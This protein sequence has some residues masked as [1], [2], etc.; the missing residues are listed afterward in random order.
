MKNKLAIV[1][2]GQGSQ[3][4]G[5]L[6]DLSAEFLQ[7]QN[8]FAQASKILGYDLWDLAQNGPVEKL[9][10]TE[11]TQPLLLTAG[12]AVWRIWREKNSASPA[13][14]AGHSL[15]EYTALV[16]AEAISFED[17]VTLVQDRGRFM[18]EAS[19]NEG[20]MV[21]IVGL[22][23]DVVEQICNEAAQGQVLVPANYNSIGQTVVAGQLEAAK[24]SVDLAKKA[25]AKIAMILSVSIPSHCALMKPAAEQLSARL[26]QITINTP[27]IPVIH[28][29]DVACHN[30][31]NKIRDL[32]IQQLCNPVRWVE[33]VQFMVDNGVKCILECGPGKIL[34]GL[35]KRINKEIKTDFI[36]T[37]EKMN[38]ERE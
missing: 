6:K 2:P 16:C 13:F 11:F 12:V 28:N 27:K 30:D 34:T 38:K 1:F 7:I 33:T 31:P 22:D 26:A 21:A 5:M 19:H 3:T 20:A 4:V 9:N 17:G 25:G 10:Q 36:G 14:M 32:L 15:G 24:R 37:P 8:T 18:Q 29:A 35:N 23:G